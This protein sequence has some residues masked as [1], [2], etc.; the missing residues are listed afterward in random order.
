MA[1]TAERTP[2]QKWTDEVKAHITELVR[3]PGTHGQ[4]AEAAVSVRLYLREALRQYL[5]D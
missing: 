4:K 5:E 3:L 1:K 2:V